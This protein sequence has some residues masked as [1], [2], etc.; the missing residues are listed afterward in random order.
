MAHDKV[1]RRQMA[2]KIVNLETIRTQVLENLN[3]EE[4]SK[5][6]GEIKP[7]QPELIAK[8]QKTLIKLKVDRCQLEATILAKLS[9]VGLSPSTLKC[10]A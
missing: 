10:A 1:T 4:K 7:L 3:T 9:H 8:R 2:C 6:F 5:F